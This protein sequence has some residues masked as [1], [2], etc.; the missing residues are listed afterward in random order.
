MIMTSN[1]LNPIGDDDLTIPQIHHPNL[2]CLE[3]DVH[4]E[5]LRRSIVYL[6]LIVNLN[7]RHLDMSASV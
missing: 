3:A 4:L 7:S 5:D 2:V 1:H 6:N